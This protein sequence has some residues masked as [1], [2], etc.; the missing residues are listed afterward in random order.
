MLFGGST[1]DLRARDLL[2]V[3]EEVRANSPPT[4]PRVVAV[5]HPSLRRYP[6][7]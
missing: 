7:Q 5:T 2:E 6:S 3:A 4:L 1:A